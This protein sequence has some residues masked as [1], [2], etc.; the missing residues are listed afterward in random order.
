MAAYLGDD[1]AIPSFGSLVEMAVLTAAIIDF[2]MC[3][4]YSQISQ[5]E[6]GVQQSL[7]AR[8]DT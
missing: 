3:S 2:Q 6:Q 4:S 8:L 5:P 7:Q 1:N